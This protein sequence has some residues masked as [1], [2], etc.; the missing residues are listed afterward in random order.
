MVNIT[1]NINWFF[2]G[3]FVF[4]GILTTKHKSKQKIAY[5]TIHEKYTSIS[6]KFK[7]IINNLTLCE[8]LTYKHIYKFTDEKNINILELIYNSNGKYI[9]IELFKNNKQDI[10]NFL[11]GCYL[12]NKFIQYSAVPFNKYNFST[13]SPLA[14]NCCAIS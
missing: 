5:I 4:N 3:Y 9:P 11:L 7:S 10:K 14:F 6:N 12:S 2:L 13:D 8:M 1:E